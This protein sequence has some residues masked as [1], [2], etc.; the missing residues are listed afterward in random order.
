MV[1]PEYPVAEIRHMLREHQEAIDGL[2][3]ALLRHMEREEGEYAILLRGVAELLAH[4]RG[5]VDDG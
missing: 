3:A 1:P 2:R 5:D 4:A